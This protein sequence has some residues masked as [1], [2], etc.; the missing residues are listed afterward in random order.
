MI[1]PRSVPVT[2]VRHHLDTL[3][4]RHS[5]AGIALAIGMTP[6]SVNRLYGTTTNIYVSTANRIIAAAEGR[7]KIEPKEP[8]VS[9]RDEAVVY[10]ETDEGREFIARCR[11]PRKYRESV[12]A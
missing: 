4:E 9:V 6:R 5:I 12:A 3:K 11:V 8:T 1:K 2:K 10:A 7:V